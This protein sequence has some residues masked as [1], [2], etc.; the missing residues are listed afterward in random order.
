MRVEMSKGNG[1]TVFTMYLGTLEKE[2]EKPISRICGGLYE[3]KDTFD[4][5]H[6]FEVMEEVADLIERRL[7]E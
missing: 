4:D 5:E 1:Q 2:Y 3:L 7:E 6:A